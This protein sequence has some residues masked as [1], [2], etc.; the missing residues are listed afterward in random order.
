MFLESSFQVPRSAVACFTLKRRHNLDEV[1]WH[2][3]LVLLSLRILRGAERRKRTKGRPTAGSHDD[4][5]QYINIQMAILIW[6]ASCLKRKRPGNRLRRLWCR[7]SLRNGATVWSFARVWSPRPS[8]QSWWFRNSTPE[9]HFKT[10]K[11]FIK[12]WDR[13]HFWFTEGSA[14]SNSFVKDDSLH[15]ESCKRKP[16]YKVLVF[17]TLMT[18]QKQCDFKLILLGVLSVCQWVLEPEY[19]WGARTRNRM[20]THEYTAWVK[21]CRISQLS[22]DWIKCGVGVSQSRWHLSYIGPNS[23]RPDIQT[24][25]QENEPGRF[26]WNNVKKQ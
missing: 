5:E 2:S 1:S 24:T 20:N 19:P 15:F 7:L 12:H 23:M 6:I 18:K 3:I 13:Y 10:H 25:C 22:P 21:R 17:G 4:V 16:S 26:V 9:D 14:E 8:L 11:L